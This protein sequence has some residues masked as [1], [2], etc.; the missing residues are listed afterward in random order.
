[1]RGVKVIFIEEVSP[2]TNNDTR[3]VAF[4]LSRLWG[5]VETL[6]SGDPSAVAP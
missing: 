4:C 1:V 3:V 6:T 2:F 5:R